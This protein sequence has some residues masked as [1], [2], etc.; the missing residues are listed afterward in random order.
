MEPGVG[1][2]GGKGGGGG[3]G[4]HIKQYY[5]SMGSPFREMCHGLIYREFEY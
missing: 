5:L 4:D 3:D 1:G 2:H